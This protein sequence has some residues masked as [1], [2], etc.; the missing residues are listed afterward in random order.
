MDFY[1]TFTNPKT[2]QKKYAIICK[3]D[4]VS[5]ETE[6][7]KKYGGTDNIPMVEIKMRQGDVYVFLCETEEEI[8]EFIQDF[9]RD[10]KPKGFNKDWKKIAIK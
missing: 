5:I 3:Q 9:I 2:N 1:F 7:S 8:E 10:T 4:I 6:F